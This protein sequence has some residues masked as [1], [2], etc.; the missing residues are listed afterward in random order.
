M[1]ISSSPA[2]LRAAR[3]E[4]SLESPRVLDTRRAGDRAARAEQSLESPR[5]LD[6]RRAGVQTTFDFSRS[7]RAV[8][9]KLSPG[10]AASILGTTVNC[11]GCSKA[12]QH[13][14]SH[15]WVRALRVWGLIR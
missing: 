7:L 9:A 12:R 11:R 10:R 14:K 4:Q 13:A 15:I 6:T 5:V 3:A 2:R 8:I 1:V